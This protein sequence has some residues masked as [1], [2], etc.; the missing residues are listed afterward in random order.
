MPKEMQERLLA[1]RAAEQARHD[2]QVAERWRKIRQACQ[3]FLDSSR[4]LIRW[5]NA[6]PD[7]EHFPKERLG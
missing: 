7:D 3:R 5:L 4:R 1:E 2:A 6:R